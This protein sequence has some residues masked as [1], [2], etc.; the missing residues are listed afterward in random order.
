M[1]LSDLLDTSHIVLGARAKDKGQLLRDLAARA[2]ALCKIDSR[3]I[4]YALEAREALGSTGLGDGF[5][6][7]HA[8]V[9]GLDRPF[10][11]FLRL[12]RP[13]AFDA[14]DEQKVDLVFL[15]LVP[16][17]ADSAYLAVLA[18]ICRRLRDPYCAASLREAADAAAV[19]TLL[20]DA[21]LH[22]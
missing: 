13:V 22:E 12:D 8:R 11:M 2:E 6:L 9:A 21:P 14:I 4:L 10:G 17:I 3:E 7:P 15:F 19:Q 20:C 18:A 5:A 1:D 16:A